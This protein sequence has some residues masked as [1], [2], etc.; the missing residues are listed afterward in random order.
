MKRCLVGAMVLFLLAGCSG[1][2]SPSIRYYV[3]EST[4]NEPGAVLPDVSVQIEDLEIPQY[5]ERYQIVTRRSGTE[6]QFSEVHQW[7]DNLRK[8]LT[9]ALADNLSI[10]LGTDRVGT[11]SQRLAEKADFRLRLN[12]TRFE[13]DASGVVRLAARWQIVDATLTSSGS[14][15]IAADRSHDD[16]PGTVAEMSEVIGELSAMLAATI[17]ERAGASE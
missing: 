3:L 6:L 8:N 5:L 13:R 17:A 14:T 12:L 2:G 11:P 4:A 7:G 10:G 15:E 9:R 1:S 16:Y